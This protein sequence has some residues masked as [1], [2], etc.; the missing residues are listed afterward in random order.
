MRTYYIFLIVFFALFV[1][2]S[3]EKIGNE[4]NVDPVPLTLTRSQVE[5][6]DNGNT[7]A[8]NLLELIDK[9][10]D[11]KDYFFSPL[12]VQ[13]ALSMLLNGTDGEAFDEL[14]GVLGY[15]EDLQAV[16]D[17][18]KQMIERSPTWDPK[19]KL[20]LA[21]AMVGN[22]KYTFKAPYVNTLKDVFSAE[23]CNMDF[24]KPNK[25]LNYINGWCNDKTNGMI[26]KILDRLDPQS[27]ICLINALY[28]NGVWRYPF[29]K[30]NTQKEPFICESGKTVNVNMMR[31]AGSLPYISGTD[32]KSVQLPCGNGSFSMHVILPQGEATVNDIVEQIKASGWQA[33]L[34]KT[35]SNKVFL[36]IPK[37]E[38][39]YSNDLADFISAL[40]AKTI[41]K[42]GCFSKITDDYCPIT[43]VIHKAKI[44]VSEERTEAAAA[45]VITGYTSAGPDSNT[46]EFFCDR[47]FLY[48]IVEKTTGAIFFVGKYGGG[49]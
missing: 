11:G 6:V 14:C 41:F 24:S 32:W 37:Y 38:T 42:G 34:E 7:F 45:T 46:I 5:Y 44:S 36:K 15:G 27:A 26:P 2:I 25:V 48:A 35:V 17:F 4:S 10:E 22:D 28:F 1:A 30:D 47:P 9:T 13:M 20:S 49:N 33:F 39:K 19:V 21:N 40:G 29:N 18:C 31:L 23:V 8:A 16:N 12:S 43:S 3:C